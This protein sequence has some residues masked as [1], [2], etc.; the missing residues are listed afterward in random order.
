MRHTIGGCNLGRR[1]SK[2]CKSHSLQTMN[3]EPFMIYASPIQHP[4]TCSQTIQ[5]CQL[6]IYSLNRKISSIGSLYAPCLDYECQVEEIQLLNDLLNSIGLSHCLPIITSLG[7]RRIVRLGMR[8]T[9]R[10]ISASEPGK[11]K[12]VAAITVT[13]GT[14]SHKVAR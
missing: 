9:E 1:S 10:N 6:P 4:K 2:F 3:Q 7:S 11:P 13:S 14:I 8:L 12:P 5:V